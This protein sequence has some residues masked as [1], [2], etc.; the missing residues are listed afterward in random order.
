VDAAIRPAGAH[1]CARVAEIY[2]AG[3][4][5][6]SA[7]FETRLRD[8]RDISPW[9]DSADR[10]P[11]L[12]AEAEDR[13]LGW[14][15]VGSYSDREAYRGVGEAQVYVDSAARGRGLGSRLLAALCDTA[16]GAGYWKLIG[17]LFEHNRPSRA[18][19]LRGGFREV[20]VHRRHGR[21]D[22]D[23]RDVLVV[24]RLIGPAAN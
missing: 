11:F 12:V 14:A 3:I 8:V 10:F 1:D 19:C 15:R 22:G 23:W 17:R 2:N 9:L 18:L 6:R 24:E 4:V 7:T 16:E 5:E 13:V 20:G 21:L